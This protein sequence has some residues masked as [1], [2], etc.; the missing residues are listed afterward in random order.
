MWRNYLTIALRQLGRQR[1]YTAINIGGLAVGLASF[2]VIMLFVRDELSYDRFHAHADRIYKLHGTFQYNDL[3]LALDGMPL[4][5]APTLAEDLPGVELAARLKFGSFAAMDR[6]QERSAEVVYFTDATFFDF[7]TF[8]LRRGDPKT[9]LAEPYSL[10]L[11]PEA[12]HDYFGTAD[13]MGQTITTEDSTSYRIT[14]VL[15]EIPHN[16][17]LQFRF[18]GSFETLQ[19]QGTEVDR[20][21][22]LGGG[23]IPTYVRLAE[24][25]TLDALK[26]AMPAFLEQ[27]MGEQGASLTVGADRLT[28]L[29]LRTDRVSK[30]EG[31]RG[32]IR[33]VW[34]FSAIG[35]LIL[36]IA[37]INYM[38]LATARAAQRAR[39]VGIHKVVGA[40]RGQL[41]GRF[42]AESILLCCIALALA[43]ALVELVLPAFSGLVGKDVRLDLW[44]DPWLLPGLVLL[45]VVV[46]TLAGS[47][48]AFVLARFQ[49]SKVLKGVFAAGRGTAWLRKGLV[50]FQFM[51]SVGLLICTA[52]MLS[53]MHFMQTKK[54]GVEPEQVVMLPVRGHVADR[55]EALRDLLLQH[56]NVLRV[57]AGE[58]IGGSGL[59]VFDPE[60]PVRPSDGLLRMFRVQPGFVETV[61]LTLL[62]GRSFSEER[63]ADTERG[64]LLNESAVR[65]LASPG[66]ARR[67]RRCR[68]CPRAG[69]PRD[70][71]PV[72]CAPLSSSSRPVA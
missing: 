55:Y 70:A 19:A 2:L 64:I 33:Y 60:A 44:G 59:A 18:L 12:A 46:G 5:M 66:S 32:D 38:N 51:M 30:G 17:H 11:T 21:Q 9:A 45:V 16:S 6:Q 34:L 37:C 67:R 7:F 42:L 43:L 54:L 62:A 52:V 3:K 41:V 13:P 29:Y 1:S 40:G 39:E 50:T 69:T 58:V 68:S 49:P 4:P 27:H 24:G 28:D 31:L 71:A 48:P 26:Q 15:E 56:P 47:Y 65:D 22:A 57:S 72:R 8:P 10:V 63:T 53:Q 23:Q 36:L 25:Y 61:G 14:G 20:W 35:L